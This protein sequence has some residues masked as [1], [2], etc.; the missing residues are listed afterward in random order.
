MT[1]HFETHYSRSKEGRFV[2]PLPKNPNARPIGESRS[3][4]V[5]R[6]LSLERS[7]NF[8]NRFQDFN[9]VMLE[10]IEMRHAEAIP[11]TDLEKPTELTFY[12]PMH[13]VYKATSTTTGQSL[14]RLPSR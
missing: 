5:K 6:F 9:S 3:Q 12:L 7:L 1:R 10:Y 11:A 4:A 13:A 2:V 8:K 14:M